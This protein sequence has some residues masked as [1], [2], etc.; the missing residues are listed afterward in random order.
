MQTNQT[1]TKTMET[2]NNTTEGFDF[3]KIR[4]QIVIELK[5]WPNLFIQIMTKPASF[6]ESLPTKG[7]W[8]VP[9]IYGATAGLF[10]GVVS[11]IQIFQI[12]LGSGLAAFIS[13]IVTGAI[14]VYIGGG[15]LNTVLMIFAKDPSFYRS[16]FLVS[17]LSIFSVAGELGSFVMPFSGSIASLGYLY[18]IYFYSQSC[19][20]FTKKQAQILVGV[21]FVSAI[22]PFLG[23][24]GIMLSRY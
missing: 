14:G 11:S 19:A 18:V 7:D 6:T 21:L 1:E 8:F 16:I 4:N 10:A 22:L 12:S 24:S 23:L 2:S 17:I 5:K 9:A 20:G 15:I 13:G 3:E